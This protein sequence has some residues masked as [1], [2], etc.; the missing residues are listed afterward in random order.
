MGKKLQL[1][2]HFPRE[3]DTPKADA[4]STLGEESEGEE[5][6]ED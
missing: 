6:E 4:P 2:M 3:K 5:S 1:P